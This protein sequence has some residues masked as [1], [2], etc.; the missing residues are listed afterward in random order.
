MNRSPTGR[1]VG[2]VA[3]AVGVTVR[4][5]HHYD[6]V[7][8]LSPSV[9][10]AA[11]YRLYDETDLARLRT[12]VVYR[13]L[14]FAL[15]EVRRLLDDPDADVA[16]H[17]R[18]QRDVLVT[19]LDETRELLA[20]IDR[21]LEAEM[22]G[23]HLTPEEQ[24]EL[25]GEE[26]SDELTREAEKRWGDTD[27][28]RQSQARV[29][30]Y[31]NDDWSRI[32]DEADRIEQRFADV[33]ASGQAPDSAQARAVAREHREHIAH[34]FYDCSEQLH[35]SLGQMYVADPRF[36]AHYDRRTPGLA[37]YVSAAIVAA[38]DESST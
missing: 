2:Q 32:R 36:T 6:E 33:M 19:R 25:F 30:T 26:W 16:D 3:E 23:T 8:L 20:A 22:T 5:L 9:R 29:S 27:A 38:A 12:I 10:N 35:R 28:W 13:R 4:T 21:A 34:W 24:R 11:G 37:A 1:T 31:G 14:G 17:L 18:R 7:G 15:D